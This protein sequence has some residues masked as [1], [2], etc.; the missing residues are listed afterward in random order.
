MIHLVPYMLE[1]QF[2]VFI[3][4]MHFFCNRLIQLG[5]EEPKDLP[6][7][8]RTLYFDD[9]EIRFLHDEGGKS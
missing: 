2:T 8:L 1:G 6:S 5:I 4:G 7:C 3:I 9:R